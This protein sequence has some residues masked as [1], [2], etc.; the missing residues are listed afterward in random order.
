MNDLRAPSFIARS[1]ISMFPPEPTYVSIKAFFLF[2]YDAMPAVTSLGQW[3]HCIS[4]FL[5]L[6]RLES[7]NRICS[8]SCGECC[9]FDLCFL[10]PCPWVNCSWFWHSKREEGG[11]L[12]SA[13]LSFVFFSYAGSGEIHLEL[14]V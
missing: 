4:L 5:M 13:S 11:L 8:I 7:T 1:E 6:L 10:R 3:G 9:F 14:K 2:A 12:S